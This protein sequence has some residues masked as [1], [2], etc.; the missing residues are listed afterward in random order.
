MISFHAAVLD[1][2]YMNKNRLSLL[3][4]EKMQ[5]VLI[6]RRIWRAQRAQ[7]RILWEIFNLTGFLRLQGKKQNDFHV[8]N[9]W[10]SCFPSFSLH[11][12]VARVEKSF[13]SIK[14]DFLHRCSRF[15]I[16]ISCWLS[17]GKYE[18][19]HLRGSLQYF[20]NKHGLSSKMLYLRSQTTWI[21][22]L[23]RILHSLR[24]RRKC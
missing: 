15:S 7:N 5:A 22:V 13:S 3:T 24:W 8:G 4:E 18:V 14:R 9:K 19:S 16:Q 12:D 23:M 2:F 1:K 20:F 6:H 21:F 17:G 10:F 11:A